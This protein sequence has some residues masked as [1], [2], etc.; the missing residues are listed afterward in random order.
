MLPRAVP[1]R[2]PQ[3]VLV[4][5]TLHKSQVRQAE[6]EGEYLEAKRQLARTRE[7]NMQVGGGVGGGARLRGRLRSGKVGHS[8]FS[9]SGALQ[10]RAKVSCAER[11]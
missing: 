5:P 9:A 7:K 4:T 11:P 3:A 2:T 1:R 10:A 6:M 8:M